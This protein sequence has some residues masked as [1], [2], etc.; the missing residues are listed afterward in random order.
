MVVD[1]KKFRPREELEPGL[2]TIMEVIPGTAAVL[3]PYY[4]VMRGPQP[5][6]TLGTGRRVAWLRW[7]PLCLP[8]PTS[9][10][11]KSVV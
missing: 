11:R 3:L 5:R 4:D 9:A 10:D 6:A 1:L 7:L 8:V 2:L